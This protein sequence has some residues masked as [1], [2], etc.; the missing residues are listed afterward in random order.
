M[1]DNRTILFIIRAIY[2]FGLALV[3]V[4]MSTC[5]R[6]FRFSS[7]Y[8]YVFFFCFDFDSITFC[9]LFF[10]LCVNRLLMLTDFVFVCAW[11]HEMGS[12]FKLAS[13]LHGMIA[14]GDRTI[15]QQKLKKT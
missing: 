11:I 15:F 4:Q 1:R 8:I 14:I 3:S 10:Q 7:S 12:D 9:T 6:M 2:R 13:V 5:G